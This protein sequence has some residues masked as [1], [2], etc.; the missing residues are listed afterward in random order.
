MGRSGV[1]PSKSPTVWKFELEK[2]LQA[3]TH[4]YRDMAL[5]QAQVLVEPPSALATLRMIHHSHP[6][7]INVPIKVSLRLKKKRQACL[8]GLEQKLIKRYPGQGG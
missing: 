3:C 7:L 4:D 1:M 2:T 8:I 5:E 6:Y